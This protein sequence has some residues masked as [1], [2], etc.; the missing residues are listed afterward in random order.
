[1]RRELGLIDLVLFNTAAVIG[2]RNLPLTAH[3]GL[4]SVTLWVLGAAFFFLPLALVVAGLSRRHPAEGGLYVWAREAFGP[5]HG[6]LCG[7]SYVL[8]IL[9]LLPT[10]LLSGLTMAAVAFGFDQDKW[11]LIALS[12]L[13][14]WGV[15]LANLLGLGVGKWI[16]D[17]G[18][19]ATAGVG[20]LLFA[21]GWA[22]WRRGGL[23]TSGNLVPRLDW[24]QLNFWAQIA[25]AYTGVELGSVMAEEIRDPKRTITRAAWMSAV[26]IAAVYVG[27]TLSMLALLPAERIDILSG[28]VQA[29]QAAGTRLGWSGFPTAMALLILASAAGSFGS[30]LG[31]GARLPFV[32]GLDEYLPPQF[33]RLHSRWGTPY[34]ALLA[35]GLTC[36]L[37]LLLLTL[38]EN[39][40][41]AYQILLDLTTVTSLFP[42]LYL[43]A[44]GWKGGFRIAA[45]CGLA[46]TALSLAMAFVPPEEAVVWRHEAKLVGGC[47]A[48][49]WAARMNYRYALSRKQIP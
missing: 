37:F 44:A 15:L 35:E 46:V 11:F 26:V 41:A 19:I 47:A 39:L 10:L 18:G 13:I 43:F 22:A 32:I 27:G 2:F 9:F 4:G 29:G 16:S 48:L 42:F 45:L 7:V 17:S 8:S 25:L 28:L 20:L 49:V 33:G 31:G 38:G 23:A 40:R 24:Q 1:M 14:L 34:L 36:S 6:F 30:W 21:A 3:T 12:L 5:W